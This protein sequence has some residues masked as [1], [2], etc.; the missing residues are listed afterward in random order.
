MSA[1]AKT[2]QK[3][4]SLGPFA[5]FDPEEWFLPT[6]PPF[7]K[8]SYAIGKKR[9]WKRLKQILPSENYDALPASTPTYVNIEAPPSVYPAKKYC[10]ITGY[11][12]PYVDP[13]TKLRYASADL[14]SQVRSLPPEVVQ[15]HLAV[16]N[17]Q[18]VLR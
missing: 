4:G 3:A 7:K 13:K 10:D 1:K 12:A 8:A 5:D 11:E 9:Q 16:R 17:A 6:N 15:A 2:P 14:Y 18:V